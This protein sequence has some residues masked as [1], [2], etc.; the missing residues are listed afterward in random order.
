MKTTE[1]CS[2]SRENCYMHNLLLPEI[3][4]VCIY[5][6]LLVVK[7]LKRFCNSPT[8]SAHIN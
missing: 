1:L 4:F 6:L 7:Q 5:T 2:M 3:M 8:Q